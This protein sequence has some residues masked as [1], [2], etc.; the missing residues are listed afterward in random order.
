MLKCYKYLIHHHDRVN[1]ALDQL[2]LSEILTIESS[3]LA[4]YRGDARS[5]SAASRLPAL[6]LPNEMYSTSPH[7]IAL[8][9]LRRHDNR[10]H[11]K[12]LRRYDHAL[13]GRAG[14]EDTMAMTTR[15][16]HTLSCRR[17]GQP[18]RS[19]LRR[20]AR[21]F[22]VVA[23]LRRPDFPGFSWMRQQVYAAVGRRS[24]QCLGC[25]T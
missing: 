3:F 16:Q 17:A 15:P 12:G 7:E 24:R 23:R 21:R 11:E 4:A 8:L 20:R 25:F 19:R 10:R 9:G 18:A 13:C 22:H 5:T 14:G 2:D 1:C 6:L